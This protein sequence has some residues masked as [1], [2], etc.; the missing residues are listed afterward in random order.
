MPYNLIL[1]SSNVIGSS[2]TQFRYNFISGALT[3][4]E[5]SE[6]CVSQ[7]VLP[8]SFFNINGTYYNN[9]TI[10]Y[11]FPN[12]GGLFDVY[13]YTLPNGF[14]QTSDINNALVQYMISQN[15]YFINSNTGNNLY[16]IQI[17]TNTTYYANQIICS[18]VP[19]S[20]PSGYSL[21][22][23]GFN[24]N[25]TSIA[26]G[27]TGLPSVGY[28]PKL[29]F[30]LTGSCASI[31]GFTPNAYYPPSSQTTSYNVLSTKTPNAT[32]INSIVIRCDMANNACAM[33]S[34]VIDSFSPN[35][36][37][38]S[39]IVYTPTYEK[40][41]SIQGGTYSGMTIVFQDQNFNTI[42]ANDSNVMISLLIRQGKEKPAISKTITPNEILPFKTPNFKNE[43]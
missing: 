17:L 6:M 40:W 1:N 21:P 24:Y 39:N 26:S 38:G 37:F 16:Y 13:N 19:T 14:Y 15:Q 33:P 20:L 8:Y 43:L 23:A 12:S 27:H 22:T 28:T 9:A 35:V 32:P 5:D 3:I 30:A 31:L 11:Q 41:I 29:G 10:R 42:Y 36:A 34:D 7:I 4:N 18:P 2:N 25:S